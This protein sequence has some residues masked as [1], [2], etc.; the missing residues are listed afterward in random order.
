MLGLTSEYFSL[1]TSPGA[2]SIIAAV[3]NTPHIAYHKA[4]TGASIMLLPRKAQSCVCEPTKTTYMTYMNKSTE[5]YAVNCVDEPRGDMLRKGDGT[6]RAVPNAACNMETY[7]GGLHCCRVAHP[8]LR[9]SRSNAWL[10][11]ARGQCLAGQCPEALRVNL[12]RRFLS[13]YLPTPP[14]IPVGVSIVKRLRKQNIRTRF[15][16]PFS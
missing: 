4:R 2:L 15:N 1:P 8:F 12:K 13:C 9:I 6:G 14:P 3:G 10:V 11:N 5:K 16:T 7:N